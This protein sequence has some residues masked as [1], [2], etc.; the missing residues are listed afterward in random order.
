M[1]EERVGTITHYFPKP[2]V[3]VIKLASELRVGDTVRFEGNTT[4]FEQQVSSLQVEHEQVESA[5]AGSE[6][7]I[8][9]TSRVRAGDEVYRVSPED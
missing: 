6:V 3:G 9:V 2:E 8:K 5:A 4:D 7:A 1:S